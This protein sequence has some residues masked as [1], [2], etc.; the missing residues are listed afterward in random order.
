[1]NFDVEYSKIEKQ[2]KKKNP[3]A[4]PFN[5]TDF[6]NENE[7]YKTILIVQEKKNTCQERLLFLYS[8]KIQSLFTLL[9]QEYKSNI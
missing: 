4:T 5:I 7:L 8:L 1:M 6:A 9:R 3:Q 2:K